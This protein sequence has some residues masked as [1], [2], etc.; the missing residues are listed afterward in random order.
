MGRLMDQ[1]VNDVFRGY[2]RLVWVTSPDVSGTLW[3]PFSMEPHHLRMETIVFPKR[4]DDVD[5]STHR[6]LRTYTR[7]VG[8]KEHVEIKNLFEKYSGLQVLNKIYRI[9]LYIALLKYIEPRKL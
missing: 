3:S 5:S 1:S 7:E 8:T 2:R 9:F 6:S 4:R